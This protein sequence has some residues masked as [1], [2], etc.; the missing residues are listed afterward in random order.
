MRATSLAQ[1]NE[2]GTVARGW[3]SIARELGRTAVSFVSFAL[4]ACF[5]IKAVIQ[6]EATQTRLCLACVVFGV[7]FGATSLLDY[8]WRD[9]VPT[10]TQP[11]SKPIE[12]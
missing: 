4:I 5:G 7:A 10:K 6:I 11:N 1:R 2:G 12:I 8:L 3:G 9:R